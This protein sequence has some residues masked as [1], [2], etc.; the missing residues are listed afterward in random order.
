MRPLRKFLALAPIERRVL[1]KASVLLALIQVGLGRMPFTVLR[2]LITPGATNEG[3]R[4]G[5]SREYADAVAWAVMAASRRVP[6]ATTCLSRALTV[7]AMLARGGC[8]SRL[9]VGVS[10]GKRGEVEGHAWVEY[11]GRILIGGTPDEIAQFTRLAA[12]DVEAALRLR[13]IVRPQEGR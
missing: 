10:R 2:R 8:P 9:Q 11:Q 13:A 12:F 1:V 3:R 5:D 7:Q 4:R 6:G